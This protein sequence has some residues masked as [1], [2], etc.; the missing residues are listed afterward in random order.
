[1]PCNLYCSE[2][3]CCC[4]FAQIF[5]RLLIIESISSHITILNVIAA[6]TLIAPCVSSLPQALLISIIIITIIH[7]FIHSFIRDSPLCG[8]KS[9]ARPLRPSALRWPCCTREVAGSIL[10]CPLPFGSQ[11]LGGL[12]WAGEACSRAPGP[13]SRPDPSGSGSRRWSGASCTARCGRANAPRWR[14]GAVAP[15]SPERWPPPARH[16]PHRA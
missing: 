14:C 2:F 10:G 12:C 16:R 9:S 15:R 4:K 3:C 5:Q 6:I 13:S 11:A 7:S 8:W 1:M